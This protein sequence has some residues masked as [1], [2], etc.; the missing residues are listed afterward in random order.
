MGN[1]FKASWSWLIDK[2]TWKFVRSDECTA[3]SDIA[4]PFWFWTYGAYQEH[5]EP[6]YTAGFDKMI[7]KRVNSVCLNGLEVRYEMGFKSAMI[8]YKDTKS[9]RFVVTDIDAYLNEATVYGSGMRYEVL[10]DVDYTLITDTYVT[11]FKSI[12]NDASSAGAVTFLALYDLDS[13]SIRKVGENKMSYGIAHDPYRL[14]YKGKQLSR[15][16]LALVSG[17]WAVLL[18]D[19]FSFN[20]LVFLKGASDG[21]LVIERFAHTVDLYFVKMITL[22]K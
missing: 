6:M 8:A 12:I 19:D 7:Y 2:K 15:Q 3:P 22:I 4:I 14:I 20:S 9:K 1:Y 17:T 13:S 5:Y 10:A 16:F 18:N 11:K 21:E